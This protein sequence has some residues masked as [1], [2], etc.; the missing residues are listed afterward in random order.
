MRNKQTDFLS[1]IGRIAGKRYAGP[2]DSYA[3]SF[4]HIERSRLKRI[5]RKPHLAGFATLGGNIRVRVLM[6]SGYS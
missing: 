3:E 6:Q 4:R 2:P 1:L 5:A